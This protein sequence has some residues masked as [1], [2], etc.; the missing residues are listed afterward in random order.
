MANL[1]TISKSDRRPCY[2]LRVAGLPVLYGTHLPFSLTSLDGFAMKR[3]AA[4]TANDFRFGRRMDENT[5][6]VEV[7][8]LA[9]TLVVMMSTTETFTTRVEFSLD[10]VISGRMP[11]LGYRL[12]LRRL[13]HR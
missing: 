12:R 9:V 4:I 3:R 10:S 11:S 7:S 8:S 2:V 13:R 1:S 5:R 6:V